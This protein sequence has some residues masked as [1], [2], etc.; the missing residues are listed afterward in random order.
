MKWIKTFLKWWFG[1]LVVLAL[2]DTLF[3]PISTLMLGRWVTL[4]GADRQWVRLNRI[5]FPVMRSVIAAEDGKFCS[6]HGVDWQAL[7][8]AV[9]QAVDDGDNAHGASTITMQV[10]KNLFLWPG[11]SYIRKGL[12][13]PM[14]I[15]LDAIWSKRRI[16]EAYLNI[17]EFGDG[18]F[19]IE[20]ASRHYFGK[21]ASALS[22]REAAL[23]AATL[24]N[25]AQRNPSQPSEYM[26][27]YAGMI[28]ARIGA[29]GV[30]TGCLR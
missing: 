1:A 21:S 27:G 2:Y 7:Q 4:Q 10:V 5:S 24:P 20:A 14:A 26:N 19:G 18:V 12:E 15:G 16:M 30:A 3:P 29:N 8:G 22:P 13:V 6:H 17:A 11:R 9:E 28:S 25:P 23:L